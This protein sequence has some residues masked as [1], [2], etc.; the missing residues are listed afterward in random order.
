MNIYTKKTHALMLSVLVGAVL[1]APTHAHQ[2]SSTAE[3]RLVCAEKALGDACEWKDGHDALYIGSCRQVSTS[4]LCVRN[5]PIVYPEKT[6]NEKAH[7]HTEKEKAHT[8]NED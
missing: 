7:V 1:S 5:K 4:L 8:H 6:V 2:G 3:P